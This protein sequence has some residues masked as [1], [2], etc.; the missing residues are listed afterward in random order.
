MFIFR[1]VVFPAEQPAHYD[2][3]DASGRGG[4]GSNPGRGCNA[5]GAHGYFLAPGPVFFDRRTART[6]PLLPPPA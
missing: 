2:G 3:R 6:L 4:A 5:C 1:F